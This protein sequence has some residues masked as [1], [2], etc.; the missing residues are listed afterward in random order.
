MIPE[1]TVST[2]SAIT[3][4]APSLTYRI[5]FVNKRIIGTV[6]DKEAVIQAVKKIL[7]TDR[8]GSVIYDWYYGHDM[9]GVIGQTLEYAM[10]ELQRVITEALLQDDRI[11]NIQDF[12]YEK[13]SIDSVVVSFTVNTIFGS[14]NIATE[15]SI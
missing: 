1:T 13:T 14:A 6:D 7:N 15:V 3:A 11:T 12:I 9:N 8:Y 5:D 10:V 4:L 2:D